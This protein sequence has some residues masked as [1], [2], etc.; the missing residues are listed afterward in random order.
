MEQLVDPNFPNILY[1]QI[2]RRSS[3]DPQLRPS[4]LKT[5]DDS[6]GY[7]IYHWKEE[8]ILYKIVWW[9]KILKKVITPQGLNLGQNQANPTI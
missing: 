4:N 8:K 2:R 9:K 6:P 7:I 3:T 1:R 5:V